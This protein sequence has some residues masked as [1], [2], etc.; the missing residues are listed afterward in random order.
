M[1]E[2]R[3]QIYDSL[4]VFDKEGYSI[5]FCAVMKDFI[6]TRMVKKLKVSFMVEHS[7]HIKGCRRKVIR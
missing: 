4:D 7:K 5:I 2:I 3:K 1:N 6:W